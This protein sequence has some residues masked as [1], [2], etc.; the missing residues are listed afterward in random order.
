M[1][2]DDG[3][4]VVMREQHFGVVE[5]APLKNQSLLKEWA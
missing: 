1:L 5:L 4:R 3:G 2:P